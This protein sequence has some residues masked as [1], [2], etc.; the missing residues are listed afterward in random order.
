MGLGELFVVKSL[1]GI[2][3]FADCMVYNF[4][5]LFYFFFSAIYQQISI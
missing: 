5:V 3:S 1:C 2:K 4:T